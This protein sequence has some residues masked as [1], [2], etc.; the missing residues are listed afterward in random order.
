MYII[1]C[2]WEA[3]LN[4]QYFMFSVIIFVFLLMFIFAGKK[5]LITITAEFII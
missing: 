5:T 3:G 2:P 1:I 4:I